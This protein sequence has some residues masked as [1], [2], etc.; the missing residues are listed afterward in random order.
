[1]ISDEK[2]NDLLQKVKYYWQE[3]SVH[4]TEFKDMLKNKESG[5]SIADY[6]DK[7]TTEYLE[8]EQE[9]IKYEKNKRSMGDFWISSNGIFT[10]VNIKTGTSMNGSPNIVSINKLIEKLAKSE[11]DSYYIFVIKFKDDNSKWIVKTFLVNLIDYLEFTNF[12]SGPGQLMLKEK[13][14]YDFLEKSTKP[15]RNVLDALKLLIKKQEDSLP[16]LIKNRKKDIAKH[17]EMI[18]KFDLS[19]PLNQEQ[20]KFK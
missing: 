20:V 16:I 18:N 4:N 10:P 5:H 1:M 6:V 11:I 12:D 14:F 2:I 15:K 17:Q 13:D 8:K 19:K 3:H 9:D 7:H